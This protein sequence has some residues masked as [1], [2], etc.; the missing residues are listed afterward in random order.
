MTGVKVSIP[1]LLSPFAHEEKMGK[2]GIVPLHR[3]CDL[4][5]GKHSGLINSKGKL[6]KE[7]LRHDLPVCKSTRWR[8]KS[9]V[10]PVGCRS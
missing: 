6:L 2:F 5:V 8:S 4:P 7:R 10:A 1:G 3:P 9:S